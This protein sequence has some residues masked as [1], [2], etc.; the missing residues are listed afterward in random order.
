MPKRRQKAHQLDAW[1]GQQPLL[2]WLQNTARTP[3]GDGNE[4]GDLLV[5]RAPKVLGETNLFL[6][7][8]KLRPH[9]NINEA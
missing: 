1:R 9:L 7:C 6:S 3:A 4:H 5:L 2:S 8:R